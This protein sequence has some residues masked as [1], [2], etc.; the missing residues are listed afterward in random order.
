[1]DAEKC[2]NFMTKVKRCVRLALIVWEETLSNGMEAAIQAS[3]LKLRDSLLSPNTSACHV[4]DSW[5]E[6]LEDAA[7][8]RLAAFRKENVSLMCPLRDLIARMQTTS[9]DVTLEVIRLLQP[10]AYAISQT[11]VRNRYCRML[12]EAKIVTVED[13]EDLTIA[14]TDVVRPC[15][16]VRPLSCNINEF[17]QVMESLEGKLNRSTRGSVVWCFTH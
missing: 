16:F 11:Q 8:E 6:A 9:P 12:K 7:N 5:L 17:M 1:M 14:E 2:T 15:S 13:A 3:A 10:Q 4:E